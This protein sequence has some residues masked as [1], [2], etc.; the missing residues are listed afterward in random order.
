MSVQQVI[1]EHLDLWTDAVEYKKGGRGGSARVE[2]TGIKK[3]RELILE[4][5]VRGKLVEQDPDEEPASAL[6]DRITDEKTRLIKEGTIKKPKKLPEIATEDLPAQLP[7]GWSAVTLSHLGDFFGGKTPSKS[8]S[9][10]WNGDIPWVTP[11]DMRV[12]EVTN[13]EDH[14]TEM[15]TNSGGLEVL[16]QET[17]LFVVR[18]GILRRMFPT[19]ITRTECTINQDLKALRLF[20]P[21]MARYIQIM[22]RGHE[23]FI[24]SRLV[25]TG[26]T[27]ESLKFKDFAS[28]PFP[29]PPLA[30]QHRIVEK[31][32]ELMVLCDRLEQQVGNQIEAHEV[33]VDTLLDALTRSA[34]APELAENWARV[35]EHFD[36]LFTTEA[37]IDK[38]EQA[39]LQLAVMGRLVA[40]DANDEP[41]NV[42]LDRIAE[43]K[44]RLVKKGK[45]RKPK[46]IS[47]IQADDPPFKIPKNWA[48]CRLDSL[49][50]HSE[51]GWSP[52]C[53]STSRSG[54]EWGVLKV[55][56][57]SWGSFRAE[58]NKALPD[59]LTPRYELEVKPNDFLLS[60]ANTADLVARSVVV[61]DS[62][63]RHLMM[64]DKIVRFVFSRQMSASFVNL[65]N[66]CKTARDYYSRVAGGTSSS[67]KNV[68]RKH[69]QELLI[70]LPP[71]REQHRIVEKVDELVSLCDRLRE[72]LNEASDTRRQL[73]EAV[74]EEAVN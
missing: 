71:A 6:L 35:A 48:W 68:S 23:A 15:A 74:V 46:A 26:T 10:Y 2:L 66:N 69:I 55:S 44:A 57:V 12:S 61:P 4:L 29:L 14:V 59:S 43:E 41:A 51:S 19:A 65:F 9:E 40:Q 62:A 64:S 7:K 56:A 18:S 73:A 60:R 3:L 24:L 36:T 53:K 27:V 5:A 33:L 11:K 54:S 39:I 32:D 47:G 13:T 31:V 49:A 25:K 37:A 30:E 72:R 70:P 21:E 50:L 34:D 52:Q 63:P 38:L 8:K 16:P 58:E 28:Q 17:V 45:I 20:M 67:M 1:T 22:S 42:L